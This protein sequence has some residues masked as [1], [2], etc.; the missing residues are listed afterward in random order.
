VLDVGCGPGANLVFL[1]REGHDAHG[2]D[3][4]K[5]AIAQAAERLTDAGFA[6]RLTVGSVMKLP[7]RDG[8]FD[9]VTE[10]EVLT[11]V[12]GMDVAWAEIARVLRPAGRVISVA[13]GS[14]CDPAL[15]SYLRGCQPLEA[16]E[17]AALAER[18]GLIPIEQQVQM[19]TQ[20]PEHRWI[21]EIITVAARA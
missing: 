19:R 3:L 10:V 6:P 14:R 12:V 17:M 9:V 16:A 7:F 5:V 4:S 1:E 11:Y 8:S 20:G 2:I 18:A 13:F 15:M 21:E